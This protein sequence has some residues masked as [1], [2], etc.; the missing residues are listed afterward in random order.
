MG[1]VV[2]KAAPG[3]VNSEYST[4]KSWYHHLSNNAPYLCTYRSEDRQWAECILPMHDTVLSHTH[5]KK[6]KKT[7][8]YVDVAG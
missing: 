5:N 1:F 2:N 8:D 3:Q 4:P 7:N 6:H